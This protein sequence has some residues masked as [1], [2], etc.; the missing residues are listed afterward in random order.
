MLRDMS[1]ITCGKF[2]RFEV[3]KLPLQTRRPPTQGL[4]DTGLAWPMQGQ[5]WSAQ[6]QVAALPGPGRGRV[7]AVGACGLPLR[8]PRPPL[9]LLHGDNLRVA[10]WGG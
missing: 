6:G 9:R 4:A 5:A 10:L 1:Y 7:E 8:A 2:F 3:A